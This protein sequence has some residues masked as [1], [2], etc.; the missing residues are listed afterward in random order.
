MSEGELHSF[1]GLSDEGDSVEVISRLEGHG[2]EVRSGR[3]VVWKDL[4][5]HV[6][7]AVGGSIG[8]GLVVA[9]LRSAVRDV[10]GV[11]IGILTEG[12][13]LSGGVD[14]SGWDSFLLDDLVVEVAVVGLI[15]GSPGGGDGGDAPD[16]PPDPA[17]GLYPDRE[18]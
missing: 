10:V 11:S 16:P 5:S 15:P 8:P 1:L 6:E 13:A 17:F 14:G 4:G 2:S 7:G 12:S 3:G 9:A 18:S